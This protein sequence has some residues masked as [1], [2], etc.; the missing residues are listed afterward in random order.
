[1]ADNNPTDTDQKKSTNNG[2]GTPSL[3]KRP[4]EPELK[5]DRLKGFHEFLTNVDGLEIKS[6]YESFKEAFQNPDY[7]KTYHQFLMDNQR[8][9]IISDV[10]QDY[11]Q[12]EKAFFTQPEKEDPDAT[13]EDGFVVPSMLRRAGMENQT[14]ADEAIE[15]TKRLDNFDSIETLQSKKFEDAQKVLTEPAKQDQ[16]QLRDSARLQALRQ[17]EKE[18]RGQQVKLEDTREITKTEGGRAMFSKTGQLITEIPEEQAAQFNENE[19]RIQ[20]IR[21][22]KNFILQRKED[23]FKEEFDALKRLGFNLGKGMKQVEA[24]AKSLRVADIA[25]DIE[26][27]KAIDQGNTTDNVYNARF[28]AMKPK[29]Q[30]YQ[31]ASPEERSKMKRDALNKMSDAI[32]DIMDLQEEMSKIPTNPFAEEM[33]QAETA[34]QAWNTFKQSPVD[35]IGSLGITSLPFSSASL[36]G[37]VLGG[38]TA[39]PAGAAAGVGAGSS[40]MEYMAALTEGMMREVEKI[41]YSQE[42]YFNELRKLNP[43]VPVEDLSASK[44]FNSKEFQDS[45]LKKKLMQVANDPEAMNRVKDYALKRGVS[46]GALDAAGSFVPIKGITDTVIKQ[47]ARGAIKG[48][49]IAGLTG[50]GIAIDASAGGLGEALAQ[51]VTDGELHPGEISAELVGELIGGPVEIGSATAA[52]IYNELGYEGFRDLV[53][54]EIRKLRKGK[55]GS[56]EITD[57][58]GYNFNPEADPSTQAQQLEAERLRLQKELEEAEGDDASVYRIALGDLENQLSEIEAGISE[59]VSQEEEAETETETETE[60]PEEEAEAPSIEIAQPPE[61]AAPTER[62]EFL[63]NERERIRHIR[64]ERVAAGEEVDQVDEQ[65]SQATEQIQ[66]VLKEVRQTQREEAAQQGTVEEMLGQP[67]TMGEYQG[68]LTQD[69]EGNIVIETDDAIVEVPDSQKDLSKPISEFGIS[70][71][72]QPVRGF[73]PTDDENVYDLVERDPL[74]MD[75]DQVE[76]FVFTSSNTNDAGEV[77]SVTMT[78]AQGQERTFRDPAQVEQVVW[79]QYFKR[80]APIEDIS[81]FIDEAQT[82]TETITETSIPEGVDQK[83]ISKIEAL[84]PESEEVTEEEE[85]LLEQLSEQLRSINSDLDFRI[86]NEGKVEV[87]NTVESNRESMDIGH[88]ASISPSAV[89]GESNHTFK[90]GDS[91]TSRWAS[92]TFF[93]TVTKVDDNGKIVEAFDETTNR[94]IVIDGQRQVRDQLIDQKPVSDQ[95]AAQIITSAKENHPSNQTGAAQPFTLNSE[96]PRINTIFQKAETDTPVS[97]QEFNA[98]RQWIQENREAAVSQNVENQDEILQFLTEVENDL[99]QIEQAQ[100]EAKPEAEDEAQPAEDEVPE[101]SPDAE[102]EGAIADEQQD[103]EE[104]SPGSFS[105]FEKAVIEK[106]NLLDHINA[107]NQET[108]AIQNSQKVF[109]ENVVLHFNQNEPF[110]VTLDL[111]DD[112]MEAMELVTNKQHYFMIA[113]AIENGETVS[114]VALRSYPEL[115]GST[116]KIKGGDDNISP[117]KIP[118]KF[119]R[120]LVREE[121]REQLESIRPMQP[122]FVYEAILNLIDARAEIWAKTNDRTVDEYYKLRLAGIRQNPA[123]NQDEVNEIIESYGDAANSLEE[124]QTVIESRLAEEESDY[125]NR[126]VD[127][128][129]NRV[130]YNSARQLGIFES[131]QEEQTNMRLM[132]LR[133]IDE[134]AGEF[135]YMEREYTPMRDY[136]FFAS[137][138]F[139]PTADHIAYMFGQLEHASVEHSFLVGVDGNN[140]PHILHLGTGTTMST[141]VDTSPVINF[142]QNFGI[143]KVWFVHNHPS[144]TLDRSNPDQAMLEKLNFSMPSDVQFG[145]GIII[146]RDSGFYGTFNIEGKS[147]KGFV[148]GQEV[149]EATGQEETPVTTYNFGRFNFLRGSSRPQFQA[150]SPGNVAFFINNRMYSLGEDQYGAVV[151]DHMKNVVAF[152]HMKNQPAE[153]IGA[154]SVA[155]DN[156]TLELRNYI[157]RFNGASAVLVTKQPTANI[158]NQTIYLRGLQTAIKTAGFIVDDVL[159]V[160]PGQSNVETFQSLVA[161]GLLSTPIATGVLNEPV[162]IYDAEGNEQSY[163]IDEL[164]II[165]IFET[166]PAAESSGEDIVGQVVKQLAPVFYRDLHGDHFDNVRKYLGAEGRKLTREQAQKLGEAF[167]SYLTQNKAPAKNLETVFEAFKQWLIELYNHLKGGNAAVIPDKVKAAFDSLFQDTRIDIRNDPS[168]IK[169]RIVKG[170]KTTVEFRPDGTDAVVGNYALAEARDIQAS[171]KVDG[172]IN[173]RHLGK[174]QPRDRASEK[175]LATRQQRAQNLN[176]HAITTNP[177]AFFGAPNV[178]ERLEVIQG[179]GRVISLKMIYSEYP[180][181]VARYKAYLEEHADQFGFTPEDLHSFDQPILL[182]TLPVT[183]ERAVELGNIPDVFSDKMDKKESALASV[184]NMKMEDR[185]RIGRL[186]KDS[187]ADTFRA[188][189]DEIGFEVISL[190]PDVNIADYTK[191]GVITVEGKDFIT[192]IFRALMFEN[193]SGN[194]AL[195]AFNVMHDDVI[196]GIEKSYGILLPMRG[197]PADLAPLLQQAVIIID[198]IKKTKGINNVK[199]F[200]SQGDAFEGYNVDRFSEEEFNMAQVLMD[201]TRPSSPLM[202]S[203]KTTGTQKALELL[204]KDYENKIYGKIDIFGSTQPRNTPEGAQ[205]SFREVFAD[206]LSAQEQQPEA[207]EQQPP[208]ADDEGGLARNNVA[209]NESKLHGFLDEESNNDPVKSKQVSWMDEEPATKKGAK[210]IN[211]INNDPGGFKTGMRSI[212]NYINDEFDIELRIGKEQV[213]KKNPAHYSRRE[214]IIRSKYPLHTLMFHEPGH[215]ISNLLQEKSPAKAN[216]LDFKFFYER[217]G[218]MASAQ[219][220]EEGWAEWVRLYIKN[221]E[222]ASGVP[223]TKDIEALLEAEAPEALKIIQDTARAYRA[224][225]NRGTTA[226]FRSASKDHGKIR[227]SLVFRTKELSYNLLY[228]IFGRNWAVTKFENQAIYKPFVQ[229]AESKREAQKLARDLLGKY[230]M[231]SADF[232]LA[233]QVTN[234]IPTEVEFALNGLRGKGGIRVYSTDNGVIFTEEDADKLTEAGFVVPDDVTNPDLKPGTLINYT[235][236]TAE[237]VLKEVGEKKWDD[238]ETYAQAKVSLDR[239]LK[240]GAKY[241]GWEAAGPKDLMEIVNQFEDDN[242]SFL[243]AFEKLNEFMDS[244]LLVAVAGGDKK[245]SEAIKMKESYDFYLPLPRRIERKT[246]GSIARSGAEV[247]AGFRGIKGTGDLPIMPLL[248]AIEGRVYQVMDAYYTNRAML[249]PYRLAQALRE[250]PDAPPEVRFAASRFMTPLKL[251]QKKVAQMTDQEMQEVI[252][253]Y[254]N[255]E[256]YNEMIQNFKKEA[257]DEGLVFFEPIKPENINVAFPSKGIWRAVR[258]EAINVLA[259]KVNGETQY[260]QVEDPVLYNYFAQS[261]KPGAGVDMFFNTILSK[262]TAPWKRILTQVLSFAIRNTL[263]RDPLTAT[264]FGLPPEYSGDVS[265]TERVKQMVPG[266]FLVTGLIEMVTNREADPV[267]H[268]ELLSRSMS[269]NMSPAQKA[270]STEFQKVLKEGVVISG[271]TEL[272]GRQKLAEIPGIMMSALLKPLEMIFHYTGQTYMSQMG[273]ESHRIGAYKAAKKAGMS[274]EAAL[275]SYDMVTG[276]FSERPG[277]P[278]AYAIYRS[279]GFLNP[280]VQIF[281]EQFRRVISPDPSVR[282]NTAVRYGFI[283]ASMMAIWAINRALTSDDRWEELEFRTDDEKLRYIPLFGQLRVPYDYGPIGA[284]QSFTYNTMDNIASEKGIDSRKLAIDVLRKMAELPVTPD[285]MI[286]P[287]MMALIEA[288]ANYKFY[289]NEPIVPGFI[290]DLSPELQVYTTTPGFYK[291]VAELRDW[292]PL[293][294][295]HVV[296]NA[297]GASMDDVISFSDRIYNGEKIEKYQWPFV[298]R[299]HQRTPSGWFSQPTR[300]VSDLNAE[301]DAARSKLDKMSPEDRLKYP[302]EVEKLKEVL[303]RLEPMNNAMNV[304]QKKYER[305]KFLREKDE[306]EKAKEEE[307]TMTELAASVLSASGVYK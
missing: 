17:E 45:L 218:S 186:I 274:D 157:S 289:F 292:S 21:E 138:R 27:M 295:Q 240:K 182:R 57:G 49:K 92:D 126:L 285:A 159:Y 40:T 88:T 203:L 213:S 46:I 105:D 106:Y 149:R 307:K 53:R 171:H 18:L 220:N 205:E 7:R 155:D 277:S 283:G 52:S 265:K 62:L 245:V 181:S 247:D 28:G 227:E 89:D 60:A 95:E 59:E 251:D 270:R 56:V 212:V 16:Y 80:G 6:D 164:A 147:K 237:A 36:A 174:M 19:K 128:N 160:Q 195:Q 262:M 173:R 232:R 4:F 73:R 68:T 216:D 286:N 115:M 225:L 192:D 166:D 209:I 298:G 47:G 13:D 189:L 129:D 144:G 75:A 176:P 116:A 117:E 193:E 15:S 143:K 297:F 207:E 250:D 244:L 296:R 152:V 264:F 238:F 43:D 231:T 139:T 278:L 236:I 169:N 34:A 299:L 113:D 230:R 51:L 293:K 300:D 94:F 78:N 114:E 261:E 79:D 124:I 290:S 23:E 276:N 208:A 85:V 183:D 268:G 97:P 82:E 132:G 98:A 210:L 199:D 229:Y 81:G 32:I 25:E 41:G 284:L 275:L 254:L 102:E 12:F 44:F 158:E 29:F 206:R 226:I 58:I 130:N 211:K 123:A 90:V 217:P 219:T 142:V 109:Y 190:V 70:R 282:S 112:E 48:S 67:V 204:I 26:A 234:R 187:D 188:V 50:L 137:A 233:H 179:N 74:G 3:L 235:D 140:E 170:A 304:L 121:F 86:N 242:T 20:Q 287:Q 1:M 54:G 65:I 136:N 110:P 228:N 104:E 101:P 5:E 39:G 35:I 224:H 259:A 11:K 163:S 84:A 31:K 71:V 177:I 249:A 103:L 151:L 167:V 257:V 107:V 280:G 221:P 83:L 180:K 148:G 258:P 165:D 135:A 37:G 76:S 302:D 172:S 55:A 272:P 269:R 178:N 66:P 291:R 77:V 239:V 33:I 153:I 14:A 197:T 156:F 215:G 301:Y 198:E 253:D 30:E 91:F 168:S 294:V 279:A 202:K 255:Q 22:T 306:H 273:E 161:E 119:T 118:K 100:A 96:D 38:L 141:Q 185:K 10:P 24:G 248:E 263:A 131:T 200:K 93:G 303:K 133:P 271:Y 214:H 146:N 260:F 63:Q 134:A 223:L 108:P 61:D 241:P 42:E 196:R 69:E 267:L 122:D 305:V 288:K 175:Y 8:Q 64:A 111:T 9:G 201:V 222:W 191:G 266:Y 2:N 252:A 256:M 87:F 243:P 72:D 120:G 127:S 281:S 162:S 125:A 246:G 145:P 184:R 194:T 154:S 99:Q 150:T